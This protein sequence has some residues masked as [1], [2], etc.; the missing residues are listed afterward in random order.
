MKL[1]PATPGAIQLF[2]EGALALSQIESNGIRVDKK[3]LDETIEKTGRKIRKLEDEL[4]EDEVYTKHWRKLTKPNLGSREQLGKIFFDKMEYKRKKVRLK[5]E[6]GDF[7]ERLYAEK[8]DRSAFEEI[9]HPFLPKY[10]EWQKL[11]KLLGT[12]LKNV[13]EEIVKHNDDWFL[14]NFFNLHNVRSFRGSSEMINFQ[15]IPVRD[16][17]IAE[18]IRRAFIPRDNHQLVENDFAGIEVRTVACYNHDPVMIRY[19]KEGYDY[20]QQ[21]AAQCYK[22]K[23]V[24]NVHKQVRYCGKNMFVF[25][26]FYGSYYVDCARNLWEACTKMKLEHNGVLMRDH[27]A[28]KGIAELGACDP[29]QRPMP[30]T[31][32]WHVNK[33]EQS[34]WRTFPVYAE[35]KRQWWQEYLRKGYIETL[36]GFIL[37]EHYRRNQIINLPV[38]GSAF[39][40]LL[41][42]LIQLQKW[43]NKYKMR[44]RIVGQIHDSIIG[45]VHEKEKDDYLAMVK[46]LV[47]VALPKAW[48]W[49]IVPFEIEAEVCD[50]GASWFYKKA[51]KI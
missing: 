9:D 46:Y 21:F 34:L 1:K 12:Y 29:T 5:R 26:E 4:R 25:P 18:A 16:P 14:H 6:D 36:T 2:H 11:E 31:F 50:P 41:W 15:N 19:I 43:L 3:Y 28:E 35:W 20:H 22:I 23:D 30:G 40:C 24:K 49:I 27:L 44:S 10:F 51:V 32:E 17:L 45:D 42:V 39:H 37:S 8:N 48:D 13:A 47:E 33:V 7:G 38:Q